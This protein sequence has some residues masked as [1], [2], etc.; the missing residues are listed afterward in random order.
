[1]KTRAALFH[2]PGEPLE[3]REIDVGEPG[4]EDVLVRI[5][6]TGVC[7][8]DLHVVR[9]EWKRQTPMVL[10]HEGAGVVE[11]VGDRVAGLAPGGRVV[12]SWAPSCG[13]C[14][15]CRRGRPYA[16]APLRAGIAKGTLADGTT[17]L[18]LN[19]EPVYR[20]TAIG[21][22]AE[23]MVLPAKA[24][25]EL[26]DDVS[27]EQAALLGCAALTGVGAVLNRA[28]VEPG[29]SVL[30]VG[31]GGVGQF[32]VQ[33]ARIAGASR[34]VAV[35]PVG[36]RRERAVALGATGAC[37]P[38]EVEGEFDYAFDAVGG[39]VTAELAVRHVRAA[40]TIVLVGM[41][42]AGVKVELDPVQFTN[43]EKTLTGSLYGSE[44]PA[45][46]LPAMLEHIRAGRLDLARMLGP[47]F[48]LER[49]NDAVEASLAGEPGR[50]LVVP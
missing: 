2:A 27:L 12:L 44:D 25:L 20:M 45:A 30:V 5:A 47:S 13:E 39:P 36:A 19:G 37:T 46:A 29:A 22:M 6:A 35:D 16:C 26:P 11:A 40:G 43:E 41:A 15:P 14:E 38:V 33:G 42:P 34:I 7:G 32:V 8:S 18:S 23:R 1:V 17:G 3:V 28:G 21:A 31:A 50:V 49:A 4:P 48:P 24:A 9:G 10:G